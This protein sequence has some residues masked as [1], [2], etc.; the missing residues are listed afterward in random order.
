MNITIRYISS[1]LWDS[2]KINK[3]HG[4]LLKLLSAYKAI[5]FIVDLLLLILLN[6]F[7]TD[8]IK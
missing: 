8:E 6:S 5:M 7:F 2:N 1:Q 3:Y 4:I